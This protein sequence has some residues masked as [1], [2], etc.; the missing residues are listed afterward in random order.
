MQDQPSGIERIYSGME[1]LGIKPNETKVYLKLLELGPSTVMVISK[2]TRIPRTTVYR[3]VEN[4]MQHG[5]IS[6][7]FRGEDKVIIAER[8]ELATSILMNKETELKNKLREITT[9]KDEFA[10]VVDKIYEV[11]EKDDT[12]DMQ[13]RYFE[14]KQSVYRVYREI[15][16]ASLIRSFVNVGKIKSEFPNNIDEFRKALDK[17]H[18]MQMWE[19]I[20]DR[21][22]SKAAVGNLHER[23]HYKFMPNSVEFTDIDLMIYD[24]KVAFI[25]VGKKL[26]ALVVNS[27]TIVSMLK[28]I[29]SL[30]WELV[31]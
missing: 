24:D 18:T 9:A 12:P 7:T 26:T 4:L 13:V 15:M 30:V 19:I 5:L 27:P 28:A 17:N 8:P 16:N 14:G 23:Y 1:K 2:K 21:S 10:K 22:E 6:Q 25:T 31:L 29:H 11:V 3:I 20:E